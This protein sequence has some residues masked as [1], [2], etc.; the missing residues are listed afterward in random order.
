MTDPF[1]V[2]TTSFAVAL[3]FAIGW[4]SWPRETDIEGE[5]LFKVVLATL[6]RGRVEAAGGEVD[7][8]RRAVIASAPYHPAGRFPEAKVTGVGRAGLPASI[9]G[10][11]ALMAALDGLPDLAA[12]WRFLYDED[13][14]GLA[15]RL[16]DPIELGPSYDPGVKL[17]T[18]AGWSALADWGAGESTAFPEVLARRSNA[19]W[20]L[21]GGTRDEPVLDALEALVPRVVRVPVDPADVLDTEALERAAA[22]VMRDPTERLVLVGA[23]AGIQAVLRLMVARAPLR[24]RVLAVLSIGGV[25]VGDPDDDGPLGALRLTDWMEAHFTHHELDTEMTRKTPYFCVQWL[26]RSTEPPSGRGQVLGRGRF[27]Q[28]RSEALTQDHV[29]VVD[30]GVVFD[31]TDPELLARGLWATVGFWVAG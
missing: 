10:E 29:E 16:D 8:W 11:Q 25:L 27:P 17:G 21:V 4:L 9:E 22:E 20:V 19:V 1:T 18:T 6:L 26:D 30:L 7:D 15:V 5:R 12:R 31:G 23:E 14:V 13:E 2:A 3:S 24:D 28:P